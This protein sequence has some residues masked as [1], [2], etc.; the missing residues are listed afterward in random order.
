MWRATISRHTLLLLSLYPVNVIVGAQMSHWWMESEPNWKQVLEGGRAVHPFQGG[1]SLNP[2][3]GELWEEHP[4][5]YWK[6]WY[7][8]INETDMDSPEI[9]TCPSSLEH[10]WN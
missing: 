6:A 7:R 9:P 2:D 1:P 3:W 4:S 5:R 10:E 8:W